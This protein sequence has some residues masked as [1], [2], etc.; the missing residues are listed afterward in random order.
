MSG[1]R[2]AVT[3]LGMNYAPEQTGIAPYTA[4][5]VR[6][7]V[8]RGHELRV[9]T[10]HP[11]YPQWKVHDGH[12]GWS[13]SATVDGARVTRLRH[14]VPTRPTGIR[15][16]ASEVSFGMRSVAASWGNPDVVITVSPALISSAMAL[17]RVSSSSSRPAVG[18]LIQDL[19]SVGIAETD[20]GGGGV[21]KVLTGL[22]RWS[23]RS[24]DGVAVIHDRFKARI[25]SSFGLSSERVAVVRNWTHVPHVHQFDRSKVRH[26]LGW[27][28]STVVLH[29]GAMGEKQGLSNVVEAARDAETRGLNI[30]FVLLGDGGQRARLESEASGL[31]TIRFLDPLP[32]DLYGQ[33]MRSAD[34]LL[35]NEKPGVVEMAVPSKLTSYFSTGVPVLAAAGA[36]STT[37]A[38][39]AS[40]GAGIRTEPGE[41]RGLVDAVIGLCADHTRASAIGARGPDYCARVLSE[42]A[43][44]DGYEAWIYELVER[45]VKRR[46]ER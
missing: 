20:A 15:R 35:V 31:S 13:R 37:A 14:Y 45:A 46:G 26:R 6:G 25:S 9:V 40:S 24:A 42:Q 1:Q 28:E 36:L 17:A 19:Y 12:G 41:P 30:L 18:L 43:A 10:T 34:V 38:E 7:L 8:E 33:A 39:I 29:A 27:G 22:E 44:I 4:G 3:V 32:G 23:V 21:Q 5:L 11:H 2:L 16:A